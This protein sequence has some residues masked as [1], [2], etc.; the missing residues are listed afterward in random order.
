ML[1]DQLL[2]FFPGDGINA[3]STSKYDVHQEGVETW[4]RYTVIFG[5]GGS[6]GSSCAKHQG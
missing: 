5:Q 4:R 3:K 1:F 2:K 6:S